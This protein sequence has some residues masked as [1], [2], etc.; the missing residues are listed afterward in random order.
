M[1][2]SEPKRF[3]ISIPTQFIVKYKKFNNRTY[4]L[5]TLFLGFVVIAINIKKSKVEIAE[6]LLI[7]KAEYQLRKQQLKQ[8]AKVEVY[9][10]SILNYPN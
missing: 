6:V 3:S 2:H 10:S 4:N 7:E 9:A 5:H 1:K 8:P